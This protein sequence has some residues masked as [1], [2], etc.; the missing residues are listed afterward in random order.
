[1]LS[2]RHNLAKLIAQRDPAAAERL[3]N[4]V[5]AR[6]P[7]HEPSLL[8]YA[9]YLAQHDR[10]EDAREKYAVLVCTS[11]EYGPAHRELGAVLAS[12]GHPEEALKQFQLSHNVIPSDSEILESLG[13]TF[14]RQGQIQLARQSYQLAKQALGARGNR[15]NTGPITSEGTRPCGSTLMWRD[16]S[17]QALMGYKQA[18]SCWAYN[19]DLHPFWLLI[20]IYRLIPVL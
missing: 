6:D 10:L 1:M 8:W 20:R 14:Q 11:T 18:T 12:L 13:Y 15:K 16:S 7:H 4:E 19:A 5:L 17:V 9:R 3:W 2:A